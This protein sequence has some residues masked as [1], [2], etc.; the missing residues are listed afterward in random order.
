[1]KRI[2]LRGQLLL[3]FTVAHVATGVVIGVLLLRSTS[4]SIER[5]LG[6]IGRTLS[7]SIAEAG[8]DLVLTESYIDLLDLLH[9]SCCA[10]GDDVSY[11]FVVDRTGRVVAHTFAD[12]FPLDLVAINRGEAGKCPSVRL[13]TN[14]GAVRDFAAPILDGRAGTVRLGLSEA[15][16]A[17]AGRAV[18]NRVLIFG[19]VTYAL[20]VAAVIFF[21]TLVTRPLRQL[22]QVAEKVSQGDL[23]PDINIRAGGEVGKL[24][25]TFEHMLAGLRTRTEALAA[26]ERMAAVGE[27]A[28]GVAHEINNPLD[29]VQNCLRFL[30]KSSNL[31][32]RSREFVVLMKEGLARIETVVHQLLTFAKDEKRERS[33]VDVSSVVQNSLAFVEHRASDRGCKL[34][35]DS[36]GDVPKIWADEQG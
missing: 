19:G 10:T 25:S 34:L 15:R 26:A 7:C 30:E 8:A 16:I 24:A 20:G 22:S 23:H 12:G 21:T 29:G 35:V 14:E 17:T 32:D 9:N 3:V 33:M 28:A 27:L 36:D 18:L 6:S 11:V 31:D 5:E 2:G 13:D 4:A 1:M